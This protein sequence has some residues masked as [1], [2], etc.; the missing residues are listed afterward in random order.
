VWSTSIGILGGSVHEG[1][2]IAEQRGDVSEGRRTECTWEQSVSSAREQ[3][4]WG[5]SG[6]KVEGL[7]HQAVEIQASGH[8]KSSVEVHITRSICARLGDSVLGRRV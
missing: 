8:L 6:G 3:S 5:A 2:C 1:V 4:E 7:I